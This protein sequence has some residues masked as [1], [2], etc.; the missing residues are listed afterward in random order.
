MLISWNQSVE[1]VC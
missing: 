1:C